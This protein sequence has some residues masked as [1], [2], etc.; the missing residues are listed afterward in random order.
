MVW[1]EL[2][3]AYSLALQYLQNP[4]CAKVLGSGTASNGSTVSAATV[5]SD[6]YSEV[7][8]P[9]GTILIGDISLPGLITSA[10]TVGVVGGGT[11]T[12]TI[13]DLQGSFVTGN[14]KNQV[15]TLLHELGHAMNDIF[16]AGTSLVGPDSQTNV[17]ASV[18]NTKLITDVCLKGKPIPASALQP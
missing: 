5:L 9:Y 3:A 17:G 10:K 11:A 4:N 1:N 14:W 18:N 8:G 13:N 7:A 16:G 15:V 12:I 2:S 6:M